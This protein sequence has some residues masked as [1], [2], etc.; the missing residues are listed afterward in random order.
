[1]KIFCLTISIAVFLLVLLNGLQAQTTQ[2][3][4]N[5]IELMKQFIG[6]WKID[7]GKDTT[8]F[9]ECKPFGTGLEGYLK[10]VTKGKILMEVK[11]LVGYDKKN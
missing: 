4:L 9:W 6:S 11:Q 3:K 8:G 7:L 5:Q 10:N 1:M 2:T